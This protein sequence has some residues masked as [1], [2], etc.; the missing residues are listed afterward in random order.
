MSDRFEFNE[1]AHFIWSH[2]LPHPRPSYPDYG[3]DGKLPVTKERIAVCQHLATIEIPT[4]GG[5]DIEKC[6]IPMLPLSFLIPTL[7]ELAGDDLTGVEVMA[8]GR[9][10]E[11]GI[12]EDAYLIVYRWRPET[13]EEYNNR[14]D[15]I[16]KYQAAVSVEQALK[17]RQA[18]A[19]ERELYRTLKAK[20]EGSE[21]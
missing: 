1:D 19:T 16:A 6:K 10:D 3:G 11:C 5:Y 20:Y 7:T 17:E 13:D 9:S 4:D 15:I 14:L 12:M 21:T 18:E 8:D 2:E